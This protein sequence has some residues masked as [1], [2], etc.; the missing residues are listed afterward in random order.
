MNDFDKNFL[1]LLL[2]FFDGSV[3]SLEHIEDSL[4][5]LRN[6]VDRYNEDTA[7]IIYKESLKI[8]AAISSLTDARDA[9]DKLGAF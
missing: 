7:E 1:E 2:T 5:I 8:E 4:S 9:L 3:K 6:N